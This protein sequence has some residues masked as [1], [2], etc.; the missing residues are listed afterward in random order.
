MLMVDAPGLAVAASDQKPPKHRQRGKWRPAAVIPKSP[1]GGPGSLRSE[2]ATGQAVHARYRV[3]Q[4]T[5]IPRKNTDDL[6][7]DEAERLPKPQLSNRRRRRGRNKT[8]GGPAKQHP[9]KDAGLL[10]LLGLLQNCTFNNALLGGMA[11]DAWLPPAACSICAEMKAF[12]AVVLS[13]GAAVAGGEEARNKNPGNLT[14][15]LALV[16]ALSV[17]DGGQTHKEILNKALVGLESSLSPPQ[18]LNTQVQDCRLDT[19]KGPTAKTHRKSMLAMQRWQ[20]APDA[21]RPEPVSQTMTVDQLE[22][23]LMVVG[24]ASAK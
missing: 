5:A 12:A 16:E 24:A 10:S 7:M 18:T 8:G 15:F 9:T 20:I 23:W 17:A 22:D 21:Y 14:H 4:V 6:E 13:Y 11:L 3:A 2:P 1:L 19:L